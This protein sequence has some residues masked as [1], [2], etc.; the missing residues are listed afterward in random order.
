MT[1]NSILKI[2]GCLRWASSFLKNTDAL[3]SKLQQYIKKKEEE[4]DILEN[5]SDCS[6]EDEADKKKREKD[7]ATI[8]KKLKQVNILF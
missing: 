6:D 3:I 8:K 2:V 1:S 5:W 4:K 7:L